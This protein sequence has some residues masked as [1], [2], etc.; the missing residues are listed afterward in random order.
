M[1]IHYVKYADKY[2]LIKKNEYLPEDWEEDMIVERNGVIVYPVDKKYTQKELSI[3][4]I[5]F[6]IDCWQAVIPYFSGDKIKSLLTGIIY[7]KTDDG[8]ELNGK[9]KNI[10]ESEIG[11]I[12][13]FIEPYGKYFDILEIKNTKTNEIS[14]LEKGKYKVQN[15]TLNKEEIIGLDYITAFEIISIIRTSDN[16]I[17]TIGDKVKLHD[18][19]RI[20]VDIIEKFNIADIRKLKIQYKSGRDIWDCRENENDTYAFLTM[21][22]YDE[23][24]N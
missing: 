18:D 3:F 21:M 24:N 7:T 2:K 23:H 16:S 22:K 10:D 4:E 20:I 11:K 6:D 17:F 19:N 13:E 5:A 1:K 9:I 14:R 15:K 8:W 12:F